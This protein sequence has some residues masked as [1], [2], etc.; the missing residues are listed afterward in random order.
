MHLI[1]TE[2]VILHGVKI[3]M[4]YSINCGLPTSIRTTLDIG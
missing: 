3:V 1:D 4:R 2:K